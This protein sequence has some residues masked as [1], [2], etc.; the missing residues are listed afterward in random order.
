MAVERDYGGEKAV[1]FGRIPD[2]AE[3]PLAEIDARVRGFAE[4][5]VEEVK[6]FRKMLRL[7]GLP[8]PLRRLILWLGLNLPRSR[9]HQFG[10]FG[11]SV[12]SSLGSE[13]LHPISPLTTLLTYALLAVLYWRREAVVDPAPYEGKRIAAIITLS[14][15]F[16]TAGTLI[17]IQPLYLGIA[18]KFVLWV[19]LV[20]ACWRIAGLPKS[21]K[22]LLVDA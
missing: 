10:T 15:A 22:A 20:V 4:S 7:A 13:S 8:R 17:L 19:G 21:P 16:G 11:L 9:G 12:Y 18:I 1:F 6:S 3:S 5:P 2:P 14:A